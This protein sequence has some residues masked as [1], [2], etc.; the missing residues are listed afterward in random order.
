LTIAN[1]CGKSRTLVPLRTDSQ[2]DV[3][4]GRKA[5]RAWKASAV[6]DAMDKLGGARRVSVICDCTAETVY[7][8]R[9][10]GHFTDAAHV[11]RLACHLYPTNPA[12]ALAVAKKLAGLDS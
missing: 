2:N 10:K 9:L 12:R 6:A 8:A 3:A 1:A 4:V 7:L 11:L 5:T